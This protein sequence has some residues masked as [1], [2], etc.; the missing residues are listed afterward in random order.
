MVDAPEKL[1]DRARRELHT[2]ERVGKQTSSELILAL[3]DAERQIAELRAAHEKAVQFAEKAE[4][5]RDRAREYGKEARIREN[6]AEN[7][8][9]HEQT[10][11]HAAEAENARLRA[12]PLKDEVERVPDG[13]KLVPEDPMPEMLGAWYRYKNGHHFADEPVPRDTSDY[14]AYRAMLAAAP[15]QGEAK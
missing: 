12:L 4:G 14:G 11:R 8:R 6:Q 10:L 5:E 3:F 13:W 7:A 2:Y 9:I 1:L 15:K